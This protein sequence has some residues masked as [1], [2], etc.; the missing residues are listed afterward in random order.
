MR[1]RGNWFQW[2]FAD[3]TPPRSFWNVPMNIVMLMTFQWTSWSLSNHAAPSM[4]TV[5]QAAEEKNRMDVDRWLGCDDKLNGLRMSHT[6]ARGW[7]T[8]ICTRNAQ[9]S[10]R[11]MEATVCVWPCTGCILLLNAHRCMHINNH[12]PAGKNLFKTLDS[13][14]VN[15]QNS[16]VCFCL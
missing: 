1:Q 6:C 7:E 16:V 11:N 10:L 14:S 13:C 3:L 5:G 15:P 9:I 2:G 4:V 12:V 8:C